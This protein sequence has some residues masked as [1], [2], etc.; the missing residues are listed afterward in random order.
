M[1]LC[2][3]CN[4]IDTHLIHHILSLEWCFTYFCVKKWSKQTHAEMVGFSPFGWGVLSPK[5]CLFATRIRC[6]PWP[7]RVSVSQ[8]VAGGI[9]PVY[10]RWGWLKPEICSVQIRRKKGDSHYSR[11]LGW[12]IWSQRPVEKIGWKSELWGS[13]VWWKNCEMMG[14]NRSL[15]DSQPKASGW[16]RWF[17]IVGSAYGGTLLW[18]GR[19]F[20][21]VTSSTTKPYCTH[22]HV[23]VGHSLQEGGWTLHTLRR[24]S[25]EAK[26]SPES[27]GLCLGEI[28]KKLR[29]VDST[30]TGICMYRYIYLCV[31]SIFR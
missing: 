3:A 21:K 31:Y 16:F 4:T 10:P 17:S 15:L 20:I 2:I 30:L 22:R 28:P 6:T 5:M 12:I 25:C 13:R 11:Y 9:T 14:G 27:S 1:I 8:Y 24:A 19:D 29:V 7:P 23:R 26:M 18:L